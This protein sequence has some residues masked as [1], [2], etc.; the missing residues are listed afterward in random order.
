V[1]NG[2]M[3]GR[4]ILVSSTGV[5]PQKLPLPHDLV[6][7]VAALPRRQ[8]EVVEQWVGVTPAPTYRLVAERLGIS[9]GTVY[10]HLKRVRDGYPT[11]YDRLYEL[12]QAARR[13]RSHAAT[14]RQHLRTHAW[15]QRVAPGRGWP[16]PGPGYPL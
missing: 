6:E 10:E 5:Q 14:L 13:E 4:G 12:R 15:Y 16:A 2:S 7:Q 3:S 8:R 1:G 9:L 11:L